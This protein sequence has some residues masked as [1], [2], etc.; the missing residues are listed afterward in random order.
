[1]KELDDRM[2]K[3]EAILFGVGNDRR[4]GQSSPV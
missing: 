4:E 3:V 2:R 1:M